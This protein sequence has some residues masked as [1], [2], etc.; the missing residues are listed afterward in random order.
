MSKTKNTR[1]QALLTILPV[2]LLPIGLIRNLQLPTIRKWSVGALFGLGGL[3]M[4]ASILRVIQVGK[5]TG[6]SSSQPSLTW[7]ALW[8]IIES[9]IAIIVGCGPGFYRKATSV[10]KSRKTPY[11]NV[12]SHTKVSKGRNIDGNKGVMVPL[13][14]ITPNKI[15][16]GRRTDSQEELV[17][18]I[19]DKKFSV[20]EASQ[21]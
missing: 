17:G 16:P 19:V 11:Y 5:T 20:I 15:V 7:L 9:S 12:E 13:H 14:P 10:S 3:C 4:L 2:M 8:S 21:E 6:A 1:A 18:I